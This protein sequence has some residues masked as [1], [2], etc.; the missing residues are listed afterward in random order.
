VLVTHADQPLGRRIA[1]RL[2]HDERVETILA[3]GDGPPPRSF[4]HFLASSTGRLRYTRVDLAKH[5]PVA[6]LFHSATLRS[7]AVDSVIHVPGHG[8]SESASRRAVAGVATR[9]SEARLVLQ[10]CLQTRSIESLIVLGSAFIYRLTPGNANRLTEESELNLDP[11]A[12]AEVRSW[13]DCD[14]IFHGEVNNDKLRVVLLRLPTVVATGGAV[15]FHPALSPSERGSPSGPA[16]RP[17]GYDPICA[18]I[19]DKDV[20]GIVRQA[21]HHHGSGVYNVA[22]TEA[23]PLSVLSRWTGRRSIGVPGPLLSAVSRGAELLGAGWLRIGLNG[24]EL[25]HGFTL[26]TALVEAELGF[27][28]AYRIGL[29]RA[30]DG[31]LRIETAPI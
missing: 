27:R 23:L 25:R 17:L 13:V 29:A 2:F 31:K 10:Q 28:P 1:K 8:P 9:T 22:G 11:D 14:M 21:L 4:D 19:A 26:D 3:V 15:F 20:A 12:P 16:L 24:P 7:G 18:L 5:R 30:G 6:E